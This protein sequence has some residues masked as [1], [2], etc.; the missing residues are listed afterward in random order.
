MRPLCARRCFRL[1]ELILEL[2]DP[3]L[4]LAQHHVL[5]QHGLDEKIRCVRILHHTLADELIRIRVLGWR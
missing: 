2:G 1:G 5:D 4:C 3:V